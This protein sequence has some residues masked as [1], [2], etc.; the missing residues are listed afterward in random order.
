VEARAIGRA[1]AAGKTLSRLM[2]G[3]LCEDCARTRGHKAGKADCRALALLLTA[4]TYDGVEPW[5]KP[6]RG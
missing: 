3:P 1:V 5:P 2:I 6:E 4:P